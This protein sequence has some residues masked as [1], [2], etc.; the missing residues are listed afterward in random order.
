[1]PWPRPIRHAAGSTRLSNAA[2]HPPDLVRSEGPN[3]FFDRFTLSVGVTQMIRPAC[4]AAL[5]LTVIVA[6]RAPAQSNPQTAPA[7]FEMPKEY[8]DVQKSALETQRKLFLSFA[9]SMPERLYHDRATPAQRDFV[10]Q[11]HH[12]VS[13]VSATALMLKGER[14]HESEPSS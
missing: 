9:D 2:A 11:I 7:T 5:S 3:A 6:S 8:R 10:Q 13:S 4:C 14:V 12:A 1:G